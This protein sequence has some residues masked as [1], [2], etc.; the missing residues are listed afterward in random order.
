MRLKKAVMNC[1]GG[2][3]PELRLYLSVEAR[4][5]TPSSHFISILSFI[6]DGIKI[7]MGDVMI[8]TILFFVI[9]SLTTLTGCSTGGEDP[10]GGRLDVSVKHAFAPA[11]LTKTENLPEVLKVA[12]FHVKITGPTFDPIEADFPASAKEGVIHGVPQ[13]VNRIAEVT[14]LNSR[15]HSIRRAI[16]DGINVIKKQKTNVVADL[17]T[18]PMITNLV[19][20]SLVTQTRLVFKGYGEPENVV[21]V[22]DSF[23]GNIITVPVLP[24]ALSSNKEARYIPRYSLEDGSFSITPPLLPLGQ[25]T[26]MIQ[27]PISRE[28]S[29]ITITLVP[30]GRTPGM[31][32][33]AAGRILELG[34]YTLGTHGTFQEVINQINQ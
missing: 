30:P 32:F 6:I 19:D 21:K 25:H 31:G 2:N 28:K 3:H 18:I 33:S 5:E 13:G 8:W 34:G 16:V 7:D 10:D 26:F 15:G 9:T 24:L 4:F 1:L 23:Q 11:G 29:E 20:G 17:Q 12:S 22:L 27:D 14:A